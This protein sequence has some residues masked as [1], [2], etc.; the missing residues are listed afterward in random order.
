MVCDCSICNMFV[1]PFFIILNASQAIRNF[2]ETSIYLFIYICQCAMRTVWLL[3]EWSTLEVIYLPAATR[4]FQS[5]FFFA[6]IFALCTISYLHFAM[7]LWYKCDWTKDDDEP[8]CRSATF[9]GSSTRRLAFR[10]DGT[11]ETAQKVHSVSALLLLTTPPSSAPSH[12]STL[13][14]YTLRRAHVPTSFLM[15]VAVDPIQLLSPYWP[16]DSP[17]T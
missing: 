15:G 8:V 4:C 6:S 1:I 13:V 16:I 10:F 11:T 14:E 2:N 3:V 17:F 9:T 12:A 7:I 5:L